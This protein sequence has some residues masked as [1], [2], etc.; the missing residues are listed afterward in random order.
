MM[1]S[2]WLV[3]AGKTKLAEEEL[4]PS[5]QVPDLGTPGGKKGGADKKKDKAAKEAKPKAEKVRTAMVG[6]GL[7]GRQRSSVGEMG[8]RRRGK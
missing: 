4:L 3:C 8:G 7:L 5:G 2:C 6:G 1:W